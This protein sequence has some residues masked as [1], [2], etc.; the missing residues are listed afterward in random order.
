MAYH[1]AYAKGAS[2]ASDGR[3]LRRVA[4]FPKTVIGRRFQQASGVDSRVWMQAATCCRG[5]GRQ[6]ALGTTTA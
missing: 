1:R 6:E 4:V 3:E 2:A 5:G